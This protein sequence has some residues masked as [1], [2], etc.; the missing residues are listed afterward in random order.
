MTV[1]GSSYQYRNGL[2][3]HR[4]LDDLKIDQRTVVVMHGDEIYR[5][6]KIPDANLASDDVLEIVTMAQGG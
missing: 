2:T 5:A 3:L 6:G 4:L 1:N